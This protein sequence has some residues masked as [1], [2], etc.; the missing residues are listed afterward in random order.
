M[1]LIDNTE[2]LLI[3]LISKFFM[4]KLAMKINQYDDFYM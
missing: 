1:N 4:E 3:I 2:F